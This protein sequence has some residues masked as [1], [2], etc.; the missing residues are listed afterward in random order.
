MGVQRILVEVDLHLPRRAAVRVREAARP[1]TVVSCGRM[2]FM[3]E[4]EEL[5]L[6]KR[7]ARQGELDDRNARGVVDQNDRRR[8]AGRHLLQDGL[9]DRRDLR[10]RGVDVD[11]RL[12][13]DL[14]DAHAGKRLGFDMLDVID[15]G[16][17]HAFVD[18]RRF[19]PT[20]RPAAGPY[21][22]RRPK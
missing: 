15:R 3:R 16:G 18:A 2:K 14:D 13:E 9:R 5:D 22:S 8:D 1:R 10:L 20:C 17:Q 7:V 21:S 6:R 19:G 4:I 11:V 12:E